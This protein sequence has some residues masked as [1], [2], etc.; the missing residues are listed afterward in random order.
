MG[1]TA[2]SEPSVGASQKAPVLIRSSAD[3]PRKTWN[4]RWSFNR[5]VMTTYTYI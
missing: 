2:A 1:T 4:A 3:P 5:L